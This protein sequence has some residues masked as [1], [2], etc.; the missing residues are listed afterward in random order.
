MCEND[1]QQRSNLH[2]VQTLRVLDTRLLQEMK[3]V[4]SNP[5]TA[6]ISWVCYL[7]LIDTP[8]GSWGLLVRQ[9]QAS[10]RGNM[11]IEV[12]SSDSSI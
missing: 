10:L 2:L 5:E 12:A 7:Q 4:F 11:S 1:A 6:N 8:A 9:F 3:A